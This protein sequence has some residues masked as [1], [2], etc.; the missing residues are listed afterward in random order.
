MTG[1]LLPRY[2]M[3]VALVGFAAMLASCA[4]VVSA[5]RLPSS[6]T[7]GV[8]GPPSSTPGP[9]V[10]AGAGPPRVIFSGPASSDSVA[11]TFDDGFCAKCIGSLVTGLEQ[12]GA[13]ATFCPNGID[14]WAWDQYAARIRALIQG[15]QVQMCNHTWSHPDL[16]KLSDSA[17]RRQL[18]LNDVWIQATFGVSSKPYLRPPF[19]AYN[20]R[21]LNVAASVGFTQVVMWSG[22]FADSKLTTTVDD[23][24]VAIGLE[25]RAGLIMLGHANYPVTGE[26][27]ARII[28]I[29]TARGLKTL[30]LSEM[31]VLRQHAPLSSPWA[32]ALVRRRP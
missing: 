27:F 3:R 22:S 17:I 1:T 15:G 18:I 19:G 13:H 26:D 20:Q 7:P 21:V 14:G 8:I 9:I 23:I 24:S 6:P 25:A 5:N 28:D 12:T 29:I 32:R 11:L 30:T 10:E 31:L 2:W 4:G 16:T